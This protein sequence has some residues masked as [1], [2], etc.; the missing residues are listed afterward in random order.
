[1]NTEENYLRQHFQ[2]KPKKFAILQLNHILKLS[3][4]R[5]KK[6]DNKGKEITV[7]L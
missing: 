6:K 5:M 1:M 2:N 4:E 7:N 3:L